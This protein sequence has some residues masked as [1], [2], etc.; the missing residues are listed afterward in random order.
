[1]CVVALK[2]AAA[3][4]KQRDRWDIAAMAASIDTLNNICELN[5]VAQFKLTVWW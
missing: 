3:A 1:M 2:V 4:C 5:R